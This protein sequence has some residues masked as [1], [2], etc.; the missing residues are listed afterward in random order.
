MWLYA[1]RSQLCKALI[2]LTKPRAPK[3]EVTYRKLKNIDNGKMDL[4]LSVIVQQSAHLH[5]SSLEDLVSFYNDNLMKVINQH[6]PLKTKLLTSSHSQ[7]ENPNDTNSIYI[8]K[9]PMTH[10]TIRNFSEIDE[11]EMRCIIQKSATKSCDLD[12][13]PTIFIKQ[14]LSVLLPLITRAVN[15]SITTGKFPDNLKEAILHLLLK[16]L[17]LECIPQN[18]RLVS[19]LPYL[20]KLIERCVSNQLVQHTESTGNV[21]PFQSAYRAN[22]S[23]ET[24]LLKVKA[25]LLDTMDG[26]E[27]VCLILLDLSVAFDTVSHEI[28]LNCLHHWFGIAGT[29]LAWVR[30]YLSNRTQRVSVKVSGKK[31]ESQKVLLK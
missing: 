23:M 26:K 31:A 3:Q 12:P 30:D 6:A 4:D 9:E 13:I 28:L 8:E 17:G 14:H 27:V 15:V 1:F 2:K 7:P 25:D 11:S 19:N 20:G 5:N 24:A 22:H 10:R 21:K 16:K 18:Y 29:A